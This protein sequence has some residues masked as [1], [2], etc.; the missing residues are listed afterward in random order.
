MDK[1][2]KELIYKTLGPPFTKTLFIEIVKVST[3]ESSSSSSSRPAAQTPERT[4][5]QIFRQQ[6]YRHPH[7]R[8]APSDVQMPPVAESV[9][10]SSSSSAIAPPPPP[11][12]SRWGGPQEG[13]SPPPSAAASKKRKLEELHSFADPVPIYPKRRTTQ[14]EPTSP[15]RNTSY[16]NFTPPP[17]PNH[18]NSSTPHE[19]PQRLSPSLAKIVIPASAQSPSRTRPPF[20]N[21]VLMAPRQSGS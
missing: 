19:S 1:G 16:G 10:S 14:P 3:S 8:S 21:H 17:D 20:Q 15:D 9:S 11:P 5:R 6:P 2:T 13:S 12:W 18:Q 4:S 7:T